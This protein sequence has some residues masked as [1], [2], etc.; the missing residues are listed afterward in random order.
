MVSELLSARPR[1]AMLLAVLLIGVGLTLGF[2]REALADYAFRCSTS[3]CGAGYSPNT[4]DYDRY[5]PE[6]A[7]DPINGHYDDI[8]AYS[9]RYYDVHYHRWI[10]YDRVDMNRHCA[11]STTWNTLYAHERAHVRGWSHWETPGNLNAAYYPKI[12]TP[13]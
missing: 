8:L 3:P 12:V 5:V 11:N 10:E 9:W 13:C 6:Y 1:A 2:G 7:G 4:I